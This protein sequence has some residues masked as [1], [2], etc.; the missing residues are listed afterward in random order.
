MKKFFSF[1]FLLFV[2]V[3]VESAEFTGKIQS[4]AAG[5]GLGNVI[6]IRVE[7]HS[8]DAPWATPV[9]AH[10]FWSF[11]F[12]TSAPGGKEAYSLLLAAYTSKTSV[13]I[14]GT[15]TCPGLPDQIQNLGYTRNAF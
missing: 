15:G 14:N 1:C 4:I 10:G 3:Y 11:K 7:G 13:V 2:S 12:D 8:T 6:L 5:P 9:C